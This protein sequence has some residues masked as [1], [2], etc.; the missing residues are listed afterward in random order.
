[1]AL[2]RINFDIAGD[3]QYA[4][5]FEAAAREVED[6]TEPLK[7]VGESLR[8]SV[9]DQFRSEGS[10]GLGSRWTPLNPDYAAWKE[11][12]VGPEPM[13]VF[14]G[15]MRS[16]MTDPRAL[17]ITPRRLIYE[18][19]DPEGIAA[20][21]QAGGGHLPQRKIVALSLE[22][23]RGWDRIFM[24]WITNLRRGPMWGAV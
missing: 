19:D 15:K 23:R 11:A 18:P 21:H 16:A 10:A 9:S 12:Q 6:L 22:T 2:Q 3:V 24:A 17:Q 7:A 5:G 14:T 1:M 13:L 4:R 20:R 8:L